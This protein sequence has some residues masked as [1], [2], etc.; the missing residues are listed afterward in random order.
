MPPPSPRSGP[1]ETALLDD[2]VLGVC[3]GAQQAR[4]A[5]LRQDAARLCDDALVAY[6]RHLA[7]ATPAHTHLETVLSICASEVSS[8]TRG[9]RALAA[10]LLA[11]PHHVDAD[12]HVPRAPAAHGAERD[13]AADR[14]TGVSQALGGAFSWAD[15][16]I[17]L[18]E[19]EPLPGQAGGVNQ[20]RLDFA[21]AAAQLVCD[22][23]VATP[24]GAPG[25]RAV[26]LT[27]AAAVRNAVALA[28]TLSH[29]RL[30]VAAAA[31]AAGS[32]TPA[33]AG[34]L[35]SFG[36]EPASTWGRA[37]ETS[38]FA[39]EADAAVGAGLSL[40]LGFSASRLQQQRIGLAHY[41]RVTAL[42]LPALCGSI[43]EQ[44]RG[45]PVSMG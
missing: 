30:L 35:A 14:S 8:Q 24:P 27:I 4:L 12:A 26:L 21:F 43:L 6:A 2:A 16:A 23:A 34:P 41:L 38:W 32:P 25:P 10:F 31:L 3:S 13:A 22:A 11:L 5:E 42:E 17:A 15:G 39:S 18:A 9:V 33:R 19:S 1:L 36:D 40:P 28:V 37:T 44:V 20:P 29:E 45:G 7:L